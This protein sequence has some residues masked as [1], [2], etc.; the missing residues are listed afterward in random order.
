VSLVPRM[1]T[2]NI[3]VYAR[4]LKK[5]DGGVDDDG[6]AGPTLDKILSAALRRVSAG[7]R[8]PRSR[9]GDELSASG[10]I[11]EGEAI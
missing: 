8:G 6:E 9:P 7:P 11:D 2:F 5:M 4:H 3:V 1:R 10:P